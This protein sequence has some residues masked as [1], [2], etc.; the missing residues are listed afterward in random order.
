M[1]RSRPSRLPVGRPVGGVSAIAPQN[2]DRPLRSLLLL[3]AGTAGVVLW[4]HYPVLDAQALSF[5]DGAYLVNNALVQRPG[6]ESAWRFISEV[7][8]PSTVAG[9]YQPLSMISLMLDCAAGGSPSRLTA[10]HR[11]SLALHVINTLLVILLLTAL[12]D[13]VW[14]AAFAGLLFGVHPLVV[15]PLAW[16]GERKTMLATCF[17][18][19][20]LLVYVLHA[21]RP[22]GGRLAVSA[23]FFLL[24][25][26]SKPTTT[27]LP[28]LLLLLDIWPLRRLSVRHPGIWIEKSPFFV[29]AGVFAGITLISQGHA[30]ELR[31]TRHGSPFEMPL[32][33]CH[34]AVFYLWKMAYPAVLSSIYPFPEP[35]SLKSP[36]V[37]IGVVGSGAL[38][39]GLVVSLR[40]T[41]A[42]VV[43]WLFFF[44]AILPTQITLSYSLGIAA[45]KYAYFPAVGILMVMAWAFAKVWGLPGPAASAITR[46]SILLGGAA[47]AVGLAVRQSR[48][49]LAYWKDT[50]TLQRHILRVSPKEVEVRI[51]LGVHLKNRGQLAEAMR[52]ARETIELAPDDHRGYQLLGDSLAAGNQLAD[53]LVQY[54]AA[55]ALAPRKPEV[56]NNLGIAIARSGDI[57]GAMP[58]LTRA[59]ELNADYPDA[60]NNLGNCYFHLKQYDEAIEFYRRALRIKPGYADAMKNLGNALWMSGRLDEAIETYQSTLRMEPGHIEA[61]RNLADALAAKAKAAT[62][63][64]R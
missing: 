33:F 15:E 40:W 38:L 6:A 21:R 47:L 14:A 26:L 4:T 9:Y 13:H 19:A 2:T 18:L 55:L 20:S 16:I 22:H 28:I 63:P 1:V 23:G 56:N 31:P 35:L 37:C 54:R 25:L 3:M 61:K 17:A 64:A 45:D 53:A 5:D 10:F 32:V 7:R 34:N 24:A 49:Q 50:E 48:H 58:Y 29:L 57:A 60:C 52:L 30:A 39:A 44:F 41:A 59:I 12:F 27:P 62:A 11:T 43:G 46:R 8:K 36:A 42:L 51:V